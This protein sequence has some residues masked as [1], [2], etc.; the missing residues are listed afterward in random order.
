M[1]AEATEERP[2]HKMMAVKRR[3]SMEILPDRN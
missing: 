2:K 1:S 3:K